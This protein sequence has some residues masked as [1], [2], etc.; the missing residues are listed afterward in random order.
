MV[1]P[2]RCIAFVAAALALAGCCTSGNGCYVADPAIP[3]AWDGQGSRPD[4]GAVGES[5]QASRSHRAR[6]KSEVTVGPVE[7][8]PGQAAVASEKPASQQQLSARS[9]SDKTPADKAQLDKQWAQ[10]QAADQA[11]DAKL[12]K[13]LQICRN[14]T[15]PA[16][17]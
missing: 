9:P 10:D 4:D 3:T 14:C 15:S 16:G 5:R 7:D 6:A 11:A 12:A 1:A 2:L 8:A 17:N 13:Q